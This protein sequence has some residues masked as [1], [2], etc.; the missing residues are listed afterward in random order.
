MWFVKIQV[1]KGTKAITKYEGPK[2]VSFLLLAA[3]EKDTIFGFWLFLFSD[4]FELIM[5]IQFPNNQK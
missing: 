5:T 1:H 2:M 4:S 3:E